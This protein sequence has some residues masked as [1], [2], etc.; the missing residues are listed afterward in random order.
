M[1]EITIPTSLE[2]IPL[3]AYQKFL[4]VSENIIDH[5][6]IQ[7]K[8][9]E[10]FLNIDIAKVVLM[11]QTDIDEICLKIDKLF[12][13][14]QPLTQ[15]FELPQHKVKFGFIPNLENITG[16]EFA[17][18]EKYLSNWQDMHKAMAVLYRPIVEQK[19]D[20]YLIEQYNGT[21]TYSEL[22][23]LMPVSYALGAS[24]FFYDLGTE[25]SQITLNS[26]H[27]EMKT[28]Q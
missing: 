14:K 23:K 11:R 22:M 24:V 4:K 13:E 5:R 1:I 26:F 3:Q 12:N 7:Y 21:S 9:I 18:L 6:L 19:G 15:V 20:K 27:K 8:M 2:E 25:L 17:D 28:N 16:G 10:C